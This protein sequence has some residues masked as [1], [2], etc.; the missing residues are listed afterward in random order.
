MADPASS[1]DQPHPSSRTADATVPDRRVAERVA[2][3]R[4]VTVEWFAGTVLGEL[5]NRSETGVLILVDAALPVRVVWVEDGVRRE[6]SGRIARVQRLSA[7]SSGL[8]I[9]FDGV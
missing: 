9:E 6:R 2:D 8:A 5:Q 3:T 7:T 4:E 1:P